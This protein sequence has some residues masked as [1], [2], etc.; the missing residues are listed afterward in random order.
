MREIVVNLNSEEETLE[1]GAKVARI[2]RG[3]TDNYL[4]SLVGPLGAGKTTFVKGF[5]LG[6]EAVD[7]VESPTFVFLNI[8]RGAVPLYHYDLYRVN[9]PKDIDDLGVFDLIL[10]TGFH[11]FEWGDKIEGIIDFDLEISFSILGE[12]ERSL[13]LGI[14]KLESVFDEISIP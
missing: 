12:N 10:K 11:I 7:V 1:F 3:K 8:Y 6:L 2:L 13:T 5:S 14:Y 9:E 4:I